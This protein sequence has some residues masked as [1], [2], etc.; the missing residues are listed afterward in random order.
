MFHVR[1]LDP[2]HPGLNPESCEK[3]NAEKQAARQWMPLYLPGTA[4][5]GG[6][7][8]ASQTPR[9]ARTPSAPRHGIAEASRTV[10]QPV[11]TPA[12]GGWVGAKDICDTMTLTPKCQ[13]LNSSSQVAMRTLCPE[14][15]EGPTYQTTIK[16]L[17]NDVQTDE[18]TFSRVAKR[19]SVTRNNW[20]VCDRHHGETGRQPQCVFRKLAEYR[21][22]LQTNSIAFELARH[23][24][25]QRDATEHFTGVQI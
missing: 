20:R 11:L 15:T 21:P 4:L 14:T 22:S 19:T 9:P 1:E 2:D 10:V 7:A 24:Q 12:P 17:P 25:P 23:Q 13:R 8:E 18:N 6:I 16:Q 5:F 3:T